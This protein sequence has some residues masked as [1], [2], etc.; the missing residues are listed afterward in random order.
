LK[1]YIIWPTYLDKNLSK[2]NGRKLPK[3]LALDHPKYEEIKTAL[4]SIG[5][6]HE[7]QK[8]SKYP[9]DQGKDERI[10]GRFIVE[11]KFSKIEILKKISKEIRKNR[12][13]A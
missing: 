4:E 13:G 8:N 11:K 3:N 9:K 1:G 2:K 12:G 5:L 10:Y 7:G 6:N